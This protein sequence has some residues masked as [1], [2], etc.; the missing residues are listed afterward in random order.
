MSDYYASLSG[1]IDEHG[2]ISGQIQFGN[3]GASTGG[4]VNDV[5]VNGTSVVQDGVAY[6][7]V[8]AV[9]NPTITIKKNNQN[10]ESFQLNQ[11]SSED[12][13]IEVPT[14]ISDLQDD[15]SFITA[16]VDN[17]VN[18]YLKSETYTKTEVTN[19]IDAAKNG[20][21][22][23][24]QELP[25]EGEPNV[26]YLVPKNPGETNNVYDEY[27]W[28]DNAWEKLGSTEIDLSGYVTTSDLTTALQS[29][30]TTADFNLAIANY[31]TKTETDTLLGNKVDKVTGKSLSTND[32]TDE[33]KGIVSFLDD[34]FLTGVGRNAFYR[35]KDLGTITSANIDEFITSHKINTGEFK[36]L[37]LG[38]YF[39]IEDGV[40]DTI[41]MIAGFD[42]YY[43]LGQ[44]YALG[45][46]IALI[47]RTY[48]NKMNGNSENCPMNS[49]NTTG[50]SKNQNNP[51]YE[52]TQGSETGGY[53]AYYGCDMNQ[54]Y[55]PAMAENL[56]NALGSHLL[57]TDWVVSNGMNLSGIGKAGLAGFPTTT[58]SVNNGNC[59]YAILPSEYEIMGSEILSC[60]LQDVGYNSKKL[61]VFNF[62]SS[63]H[64]NRKA[65]W[66]RSIS[67]NYTFVFVG[68]TGACGNGGASMALP[69]RPL[70]N[71]G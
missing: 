8:P 54:I 68:Y 12:I 6:I 26:I 36:D 40:H 35:G 28:Q 63:V 15:S 7:Q 32:Y 59:C 41:W 27:I 24:V 37:G 66:T 62:I 60:G 13:N 17:L 65:F 51:L 57:K 30:V 38:D 23:K 44:N 34:S 25:E 22:E 9:N 4:E 20:R 31:Y 43:N 50:V 42:L 69:T 11:Q 39:K 56:K 1:N 10:V 29:Y 52:T 14:K 64:F 67:S 3:G 5:K 18:Y 55:L 2:S 45:H 21:F 61:P 48:L 19:L 49:T 47:P 71:I 16:T 58:G 46:H 33:D 53:Q 70:I